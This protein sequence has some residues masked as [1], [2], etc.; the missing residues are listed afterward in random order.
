MNEDLINEIRKQ[1]DIVEVIGSYVPLT[2]RGKN[3]FGICPFHDDTNPSL[4]VS[5]EKQ[6]Y[7]CFSCGEAGN[8]YTFLMKYENIT[9]NEALE[10]L[11]KRVGIK[12]GLKEKKVFSDDQK[13]YDIYSLTMKL[14]QNNLRQS[15]KAMDYLQK[16]KISNEEIS[17]FEIGLSFKG[18]KLKQVLLSKNYNEVLLEDLGLVNSEHDT[19]QN[20][21]MFPLSNL[22]GDIV[23]FSG[24]IYEGNDPSKYINTKETKIFKKSEILYNYKR[25][26]DEARLKKEIIVVEGFM[27]VIR[28]S[29][30]GINNVVALMGTALTNGQI[31]ILKKMAPSITLSL[32][33]DEAGIKA[34]LL[35]GKTLEEK[36]LDVSVIPLKDKDPD[37]AII[38]DKDSFLELYKHKVDFLDFYLSKIKTFFDINRTKG[39]EEYIKT[40]VKD[41]SLIN[42]PLRREIYLKKLAKE[43]NIEYNT[44]VLRLNNYNVLNKE[45]KELERKKDVKEEGEPLDKWIKAANGLVRAMLEDEMALK[46]YLDSDVIIP[47][48]MLK[49]LAEEIVYFYHKNGYVNEAD[50]FTYLQDKEGLLNELKEVMKEKKE[51]K[52]TKELITDYIKVIKEYEEIEMIKKL[53]KELRETIDI[54]EKAKIADKIRLIKMGR[55]D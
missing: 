26:K 6:I 46:M 21:I 8:V 32:D 25:A 42:D 7:K 55:K 20:R 53:E 23:A 51:I 45:K 1:N 12:T 14:Y 11:G 17:K 10:K 33:G 43:T 52:I 41:I 49:I 3:Y 38:K 18:D 35:N 54:K 44:L 28:L 50:M 19:Y 36:G 34:T 40:V 31:N 37:E 29:S 27:D 16:R 39:L 47:F 5:K 13:L 48:K 4:S 15:K 9:F 30:I 24:R 2:K 22:E